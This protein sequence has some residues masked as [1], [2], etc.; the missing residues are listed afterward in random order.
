[1]EK[2]IQVWALEAIFFPYRVKILK[3]SPLKVHVLQKTIVL[4][5]YLIETPL[6][7]LANSADP[8]QA[9][10]TPDQDLWKYNPTQVDLTSNFCVLC[11]N[12]KV[13]LCNYS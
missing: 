5:L 10:L 1:M 8:D 11:T 13:Y 3:L 4:T 6:N 7:T 2:Q 9:A 12:V